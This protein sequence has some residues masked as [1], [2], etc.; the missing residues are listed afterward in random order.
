MIGYGDKESR[1]A[2]HEEGTAMA[3]QSQSCHPLI[4]AGTQRRGAHARARPGEERASI[5]VRMVWGEQSR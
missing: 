1:W 4:A 5:T 3:A 2:K